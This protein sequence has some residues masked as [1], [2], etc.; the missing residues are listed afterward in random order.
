MTRIEDLFRV[1]LDFVHEWYCPEIQLI[2]FNIGYRHEDYG[3]SAYAHAQY[4]FYA[5]VHR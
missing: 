2:P 5:N 1:D 4:R 3:S